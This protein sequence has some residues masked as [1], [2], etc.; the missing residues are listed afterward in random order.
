ML[1]K[2]LLEGPLAKTLSDVVQ[3]RVVDILDDL[4]VIEH[5]A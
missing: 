5:L 2:H 3:Q 4:R 1:V